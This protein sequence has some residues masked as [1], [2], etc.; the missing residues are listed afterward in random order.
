M[1]TIPRKDINRPTFSRQQLQVYN[2]CGRRHNI[3]TTKTIRKRRLLAG[4][5]AHDDDYD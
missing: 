4:G 5:K 3:T 1:A 2:A